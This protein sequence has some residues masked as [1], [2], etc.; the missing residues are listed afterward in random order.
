[1]FINNKPVNVANIV[2]YVEGLQ[3]SRLST[4][5]MKLTK[6][7]G[8][9]RTSVRSKN[10]HQE[11]P[12]T[13]YEHEV[14]MFVMGAMEHLLK[15]SVSSSADKASSSNRTTILLGKLAPRLHL[16]HIYTNSIW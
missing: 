16:G 6:V 7:I 13:A 12:F 11:I 15:R 9:L 4:S 3:L 8:S 10:V 14:S 2:V 1:V 5:V